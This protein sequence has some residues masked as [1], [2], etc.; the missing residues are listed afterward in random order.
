MKLDGLDF[1]FVRL[2]TSAA[3][4]AT[5]IPIQPFMRARSFLR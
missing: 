2:D 3:S 5:S 1:C 4:I